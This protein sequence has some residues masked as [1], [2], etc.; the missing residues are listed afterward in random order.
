MEIMDLAKKPFR[1][2][3]IP[4]RSMVTLSKYIRPD[5]R[6]TFVPLA[7]SFCDRTPQLKALP[8]RV[9][10]RPLAFYNGT[11]VK[12]VRDDRRRARNKAG[13]Q[14]YLGLRNEK[15]L[16]ALVASEIGTSPVEV[17]VREIK[18]LLPSRNRLVFG[19]Y[20][21]R[22]YIKFTI[23]DGPLKLHH[24]VVGIP[25][26]YEWCYFEVGS[27]GDLVEDK[28]EMTE[29]GPIT[30]PLP[31]PKLIPRPYKKHKKAVHHT[32]YPYGSVVGDPTKGPT[33]P[34]YGEFRVASWEWLGLRRLDRPPKDDTAAGRIFL[35]DLELKE[36]TELRNARDLE[37]DGAA[38]LAKY[39]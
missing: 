15:E 6:L 34:Y 2:D 21:Y 20:T 9:T 10:V 16:R 32:I 31:K 18:A 29:H 38:V 17:P 8:S 19:I 11:D 22:R 4:N 33:Y 28:T 12:G 25:V 35:T 39:G 5:M 24:F 3:A 13:I 36:M 14:R 30:V 37:K 27:C 7:M 23:Q 1:V 26:A